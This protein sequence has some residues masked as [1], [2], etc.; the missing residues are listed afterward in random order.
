MRRISTLGS[1]VAALVLLSSVSFAAPKAERSNGNKYFK[2]SGTVLQIHTRE[3]TLLIRE[4]LSKQLYLIEVPE[5]VTFK[6]TFGRY[7]RM[8]EP[9]FGD[10][11]VNER[12]EFRCV[13]RNRD[14]L[15]QLTDDSEVIR[16]IAAN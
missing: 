12:V 1:F 5:G 14:H 9:G 2:V 6:I 15:A 10:V 8:A 7:M 4:R 3:R 11:N 13:R 16:L